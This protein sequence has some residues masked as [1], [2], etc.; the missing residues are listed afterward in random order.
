MPGA[1]ALSAVKCGCAASATS[2]VQV[3]YFKKY[4]NERYEKKNRLK[5]DSKLR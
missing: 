3:T 2:A 5:I 4:Q 1:F